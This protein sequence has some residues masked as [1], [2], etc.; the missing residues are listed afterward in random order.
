MVTPWFRRHHDLLHQ[1]ILSNFERRARI[2]CVSVAMPQ[3]DRTRV[4]T[5][6]FFF[7]RRIPLDFA[8]VHQLVR[9]ITDEAHVY[10][11]TESKVLV[12]CIVS[13]NDGG[14]PRPLRSF[15]SSASKRFGFGHNRSQFR[16]VRFQQTGSLKR[17]G[18]ATMYDIK[19]TV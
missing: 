13:S 9:N 10:S 11:E 18:S 15:S 5:L 7:L 19:M 16:S 6:P 1:G 4:R 2:D 17:T 3:P 14:L 12:L 8:S